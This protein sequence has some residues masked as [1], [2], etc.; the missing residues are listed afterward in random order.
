MQLVMGRERQTNWFANAT[1]LATAAGST[2]HQKHRRLQPKLSLPEV[3]QTEA[4]A[5]LPGLSRPSAP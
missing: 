3:T 1:T 2:Q 5:Q 4:E